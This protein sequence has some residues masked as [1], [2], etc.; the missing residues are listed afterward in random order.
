MARELQSRIISTFSRSEFLVKLLPLGLTIAGVGFSAYSSMSIGPVTMQDELVYKLQSADSDLGN[1]RFGNYLH[2]LIYSNALACGPSFY[3]CVK[4]LNSAFFGVYLLCFGL[5]ASLVLGRS[6]GYWLPAVLSFSGAS[7]YVSVFM[8]ESMYMALVLAALLFGL[9]A[10]HRYKHLVWVSVLILVLASLTKPHALLFLPSFVLLWASSRVF[11]LRRIKI[12]FAG[13]A[14]GLAFFVTRS[15]LGF[16]MAGINGLSPVPVGYGG[17][18]DTPE[19]GTEVA[20]LQGPASSLLEAQD[21]PSLLSAFTNHLGGNVLVLLL[22]GGPLVFT[23]LGSI[24]PERGKSILR[25]WDSERLSAVLLILVFANGLAVGVFAGVYFVATDGDGFMTR[26]M[27]RYWDFLVPLAAI[28]SFYALRRGQSAKHTIF[29]LFLVVMTAFAFW[30]SF[31]GFLYQFDFS[32][33]DGA[34]VA[35]AA[36]ANIFRMLLALALI[37]GIL[38]LTTRLYIA[39]F[40][41]LVVS[42]LSLSLVMIPNWDDFRSGTDIASAA[43]GRYLSNDPLNSVSKL[44]IVSDRNFDARSTKFLSNALSADLFQAPVG[45]RVAMNRFSSYDSVVV[46]G[47]ISVID[48][49]DWLV[50]EAQGQFVHFEKREVN[51]QKF[52]LGID[53]QDTGIAKVT[54]PHLLMPGA[55]VSTQFSLELSFGTPIAQGE[56]IELSVSLP[57]DVKDRVIIMR[58]GRDEVPVNINGLGPQTISFSVPYELDGIAIDSSIATF[59]PRD[60]YFKADIGL[61]VHR[62]SIID[63]G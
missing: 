25:D 56:T 30:G 4:V 35:A 12:L 16:L 3:S 13:A 8:P 19:L 5:I 54:S 17:P 9:L 49:K 2:S 29:G 37:F 47:P 36:S 61:A 62:I 46:V 21:A 57:Q 51:S 53:S 55:A 44:A 28:S 52:G 40:Y 58:L 26:L 22:I 48:T 24:F 41:I 43:A 14:S 10:I 15:F 38:L 39:K 33:T 7:A 45:S 27:F 60:G 50:A 18:G 34:V 6:F 11:G 23:S 31:S 63:E 59:S 1:N 32:Y 42:G 20:R